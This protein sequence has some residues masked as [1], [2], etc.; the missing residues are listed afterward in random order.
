MV[1]DGAP[2]NL[3]Y[4]PDGGYTGADLFTFRVASGAQQSAPAE[5]K[6][7]VTPT[8]RHDATGRAVDQPG[9]RGI[10]PMPSPASFTDPL[11]VG[12]Y[13]LVTIQFSEA[14]DAATVGNA[15][16][17]FRVDGQQVNRTMQFVAGLNQ[18]LLTPRQALIK[19][20]SYT[21]TVTTGVKDGRDNAL[22]GPFSASLNWENQRRRN[23]VYL[24][25]VVR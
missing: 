4:T 13:P 11:G 5:V 17:M 19:N 20:H 12:Y 14:L 21:V 24:P 1:S 6:I 15:N 3:S 22:A 10:L 7:D 23:K 2:P 18:V 25:L 16:V 9:R 8:R